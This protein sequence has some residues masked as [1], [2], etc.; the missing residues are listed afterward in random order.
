MQCSV[1]PDAAHIQEETY[2]H[3][4]EGF[5]SMLSSSCPLAYDHVTR[6]DSFTSME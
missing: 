5:F 4:A 3:S 1:R 2:D 6:T